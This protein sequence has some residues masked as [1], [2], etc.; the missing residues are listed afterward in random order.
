MND[1]PGHAQTISFKTET[2][3]YRLGLQ[4][5]LL[6]DW[7]IQRSWGGIYSRIHGSKQHAFPTLELAEKHLALLTKKRQQKKYQQY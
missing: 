4:Q 6:G 1:N 7:I 5:D 3:Y 2:R